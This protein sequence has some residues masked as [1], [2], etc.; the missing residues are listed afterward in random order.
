MKIR[1]PN[2]YLW[3]A[4][5]RPDFI[6]MSDFDLF[7]FL[8]FWHQ[9]SLYLFSQ[10]DVPSACFP[11][12]YHSWPDGCEKVPIM[13]HASHRCQRQWR[14]PRRKLHLPRYGG[15]VQGG[16]QHGLGA[17]LRTGKCKNFSVFAPNDNQHK[18]P[19]SSFFSIFSPP[20]FFPFFSIFFF[21][22]IES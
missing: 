14:K 8:I 3:S 4:A 7:S 20:F 1:W 12:A 13:D 9:S 5:P 11:C 17:L 21:N 15:E 19:F 10:R 22:H 16:K 18:T 2:L 6:S